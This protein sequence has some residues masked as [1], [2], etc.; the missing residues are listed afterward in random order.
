MGV[1]E[2]IRMLSRG[3]HR[4]PVRRMAPDQKTKAKSFVTSLL[5][6]ARAK[7]QT[8]DEPSLEE[9]PDDDHGTVE[10]IEAAKTET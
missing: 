2:A 7:G 1:P 9:E 10:M 3:E 5:A 6:L 4:R 8:G